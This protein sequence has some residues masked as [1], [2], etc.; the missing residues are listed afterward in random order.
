M[1]EPAGIPARNAASIRWRSSPAPCDLPHVHLI[2]LGRP[3]RGRRNCQ[4][5]R[6][7]GTAVRLVLWSGRLSSELEDRRVERPLVRVLPAGIVTSIALGAT[8]RP[9]PQ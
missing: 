9:L 4:D 2:T 8:K 7:R 6:P 3:A 5:N 1:A